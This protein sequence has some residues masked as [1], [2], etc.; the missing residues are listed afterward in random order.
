MPNRRNILLLSAGRRV[1]LARAFRKVANDHDAQLYTA[2]MRPE[3]SS[4]CQDQG[5]FVSVPA[6]TDPDYPNALAS[7]CERLGI[8]L[9][10]PTIDTELHILAALR[11][12]F[13]SAGT[14][15]IVCDKYLIDIARDKRRTAEFFA[16]FGV[17]SPELFP[18]DAPRYPA[19]AKPFNGSL[20]RDVTVLNKPED[21]T[22]NV[23]ETEDLMLAQYIDPATHDEFTC[24]AY[25]SRSGSLRCVVPRQ[26]I[27]VRGGEVAKGRTVK[28][29]IVDLFLSNLSRI[30]GARGC[31]TF[32][33]FR[34]RDTGALYLIELNA[35][36]GG[37]FPLSYAAGANYPCWLYEEWITGKDIDD[38]D[39]WENGLTM[40]RYDDAV[41]VSAKTGQHD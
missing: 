33:F 12:S 35:R 3:M 37:G 5:V 4:A 31:L 20:S 40:L 19:I 14:A 26:R 34:N 32:Q 27:E 21:F 15:L 11:D 6:V 41:F 39:Q 29:N 28:N 17:N 36:F 16:T 30:S 8:G 1:S 23:R 9:V 22:R 10:I 18:I 2:D 13:M 7:L 24:D 25:F 38:F